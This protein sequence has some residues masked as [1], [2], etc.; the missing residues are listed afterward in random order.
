MRVFG[1]I[2]QIAALSVL[3][4]EKQ[5]SLSDTIAAYRVGHDDARLLQ[6]TLQQPFEEALGDVGV[7]SWLNQDIVDDASLMNG[8]PDPT[9]VVWL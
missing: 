6:Q 7:P 1:P 8:A 5:L 9:S 2:I 4:A 3:D